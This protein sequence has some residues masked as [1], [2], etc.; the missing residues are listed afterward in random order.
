MVVKERNDSALALEENI[1]SSLS[2]FVLG[3]NPLERV[4]LHMLIP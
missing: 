4:K 1:L 2:N 3:Y